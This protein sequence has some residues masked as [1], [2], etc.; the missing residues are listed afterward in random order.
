MMG[1]Q[2]ASIAATARG[3]W[4]QLTVKTVSSY[5]RSAL[6]DRIVLSKQGTTKLFSKSG[7]APGH[8]AG[9]MLASKAI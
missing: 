8:C 2:K 9:K 1:Q 4:E 7:Q 6:C 5:C 3:C